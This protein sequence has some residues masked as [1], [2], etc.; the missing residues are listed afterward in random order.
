MNTLTWILNLSLAVALAALIAAKWS[1]FRMAKEINRSVEPRNRVS[2]SWWPNYKDR[3]VMHMYHA[4]LPHGRWYT[5][6]IG[7]LTGAA[8]VFLFAL[9]LASRTAS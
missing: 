3:R 7:S 8:L 1:V 5:V 6:Y 2:L 9:I 4:V